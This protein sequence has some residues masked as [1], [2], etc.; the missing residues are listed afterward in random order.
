MG[1]QVYTKTSIVLGFIS[2]VLAVAAAHAEPH[3]IEVYITAAASQNSAKVADN[4]SNAGGINI[5][6]EWH[7]IAKATTD[8]SFDGSSGVAEE[9]QNS[10]ANSSLQNAISL[11]Y[12]STCSACLKTGASGLAIT[13]GAASNTAQVNENLDFPGY[14]RTNSSSGGGNSGGGGGNGNTP[15]GNGLTAQGSDPFS[16]ISSS[17]NHDVGIFSA[18]QN[19]GNNSALQSS[20]AVGAIN[21]KVDKVVASLNSAATNS[22][23]SQNNFSYSFDTPTSSNVDNSF[24]GSTGVLT[25]NQNS[26]SNSLMQNSATITYLNV[27]PATS[28]L[29]AITTAEA[30]N[31]ASLAN[32]FSSSQSQ[33]N[34]SRMSNSFNGST[35]VLISNQNSGANSIT[36]NVTSVADITGN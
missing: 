33:T 22:G 24:N 19:S 5:Y 16:T 13:A 32:N 25:L 14:G 12:I 8:M 17:F 21:M 26:G 18:N 7:Y 35:G 2:P 4:F 29:L 31:T 27:K 10:G 1:S 11:A 34:Q 15:G 30:E 3:S 20:V 23:V 36:Q 6:G 28:G 9:S